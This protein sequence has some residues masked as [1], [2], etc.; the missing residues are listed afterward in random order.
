MLTQRLVHV[1]QY[2][3]SRAVATSGNDR[4]LQAFPGYKGFAHTQQC[5]DN[6]HDRWGVIGK[7]QAGDEQLSACG[8]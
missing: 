7:M 8:A 6:T 1:G 2:G 3:Q 4:M 5:L